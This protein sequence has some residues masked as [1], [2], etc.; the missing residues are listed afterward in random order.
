[1]IYQCPSCEVQYDLE[2][3]QAEEDGLHVIFC[4]FCGHEE[5]PELDFD[6]DQMDL[7]EDAD[8]EE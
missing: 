4:P 5:E 2:S 6:N 8:Y 3:K 7:F 1:M